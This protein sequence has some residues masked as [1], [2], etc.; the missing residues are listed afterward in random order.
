MVTQIK[1]E[2]PHPKPGLIEN[3]HKLQRKVD[4]TKEKYEQKFKSYVEYRTNVARMCLQYKA[5][6]NISEVN[7]LSNE[8]NNEVL[9][10]RQSRNESLKAM[11]A[12]MCAQE[13]ITVIKL[14]HGVSNG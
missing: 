5:A 12:W 14:K 10:M 9:R 3:V 4:G 2:S 7:K 11:K 6:K 13:D 1:T 8:I